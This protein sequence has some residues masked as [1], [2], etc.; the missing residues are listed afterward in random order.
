MID[1]RENTDHANRR[2][3]LPHGLGHAGK[4]SGDANAKMENHHHERA[5]IAVCQMR[6]D[7]RHGPEQHKACHAKDDDILISKAEMPPGVISRLGKDQHDE[8]VQKVAD[9]QI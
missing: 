1:R 2:A 3:E 7:R 6:G 8:M 5:R 9:V 4:H